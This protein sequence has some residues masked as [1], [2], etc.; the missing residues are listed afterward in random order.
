MGGRDRSCASPPHSRERRC[1][2]T[3]PVSNTA[4]QELA[5]A[6][7]WVRTGG[8]ASR[9]PGFPRG[10]G[11]R[12]VLP[13]APDERQQRAEIATIGRAQGGEVA[14]ARVGRLHEVAAPP[15]ERRGSLIGEQDVGDQ[16]RVP[17]VAIGEAVDR[18]EPVMEAGGGFIER[19]RPVLQPVASVVQQVS[20][21]RADLFG[22]D[23]DVA[24]RRAEPPGPAPRAVEI[25]RCSSRMKPSV[26]TSGRRAEASHEA[27]GRCWPAPTR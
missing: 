8:V 13:S 19:V 7:A 5:P 27:R 22:R 3:S 16:A 2:G 24:L 18:D 15:R 4:G 21:L 1:H 26:S 14:V 25:R 9:Y 10:R 6:A 17:A 11:R 12:D 23:A 20:Q